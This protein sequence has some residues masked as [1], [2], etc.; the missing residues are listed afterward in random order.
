V[1][2]VA[3]AE[4]GDASVERVGI[5]ALVGRNDLVIL[6]AVV[7]LGG[8]PDD[9]LVVGA[10]HGMP[11]LNLG[12]GGGAVGRKQNRAG[13]EPAQMPMLVHRFLLLKGA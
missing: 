7:E 11:P 6:L 3:G 8:Q 4:G 1:R 2:R 12:L 5:A 9:H 10:G 13:N